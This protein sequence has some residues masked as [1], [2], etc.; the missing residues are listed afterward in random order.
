ML[1]VPILTI[2]Q[3]GAHSSWAQKDQNLRDVVEVINTARENGDVEKIEK[4]AGIVDEELSSES[5]VDSSDEDVPDGSAGH[6][7]GPVDQIK[8]YRKKE[9]GLHRRHRG[10]MQWKTPRTAKWVKHKVEAAGDKVSS[11]FDRHTG[12][13]GVET[14]V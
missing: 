1:T 11:V 4:K 14:E 12:Q 3:G 10:I 2:S 5:D 6:E 9:Q 8:D 13:A 7:Q